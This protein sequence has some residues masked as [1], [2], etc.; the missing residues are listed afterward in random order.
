M[1][2]IPSQL[3][4]VSQNI[5]KHGICIILYFYIHHRNKR[6]SCKD[7]FHFLSTSNPLN[8]SSVIAFSLEKTA[9][10]IREFGDLYT[11]QICKARNL[12]I[13]SSLPDIGQPKLQLFK[14]LPAPLCRSH[15]C[16]SFGIFHPAVK[17]KFGC[18]LLF[19]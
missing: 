7:W 4:T 3:T 9:R 18:L 2:L 5:L 12:W 1:L 10:S 11:C 19:K 15:H 6:S 17:V 14:T 8:S 16:S 13:D